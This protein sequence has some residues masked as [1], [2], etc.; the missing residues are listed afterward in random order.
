MLSVCK[1]P[2][3]LVFHYVKLSCDLFVC[4]SLICIFTLGYK[5]MESKGHACLIRSLYDSWSFG[6]GK[7]LGRPC[8]PNAEEGL[9]Y[10]S[11]EVKYLRGE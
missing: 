4:L 2:L 11:K 9:G 5:L 7:N 8:R 3:C 6:N 10:K 1:N